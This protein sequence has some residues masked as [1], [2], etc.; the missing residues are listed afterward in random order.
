MH[1][2]NQGQQRA[3]QR[4]LEAAT[5]K[6]CLTLDADDLLEPRAAELCLEAFAAHPE[7]DAVVGDALITGP[8]GATVLRRHTQTRIAGWPEVLEYN[9]YGV[10]LGVMTRTSS[11]RA[12]GGL[13]FEHAGCEDWDTWAR[14]TRLGMRFVAVGAVLGRYRQTGQ[15]HSRRVLGNLRAT[16]IY[17]TK[18]NCLRVCQGGPIAVVYPDGVNRLPLQA[19]L[20]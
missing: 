6:F 15:N 3:R 5:G 14:M 11:L 19:G 4:G 10:N 17:R 13:A 12:A 18:A 9:P 8:D 7:A 20:F 16:M 2:A 1:Q